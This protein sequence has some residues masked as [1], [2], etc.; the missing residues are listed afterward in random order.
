MQVRLT[1]LI[2]GVTIPV[3]IVSLLFVSLR[4][5]M[6]L[7]QNADER[8]QATSRALASNV[9][10]WL[11]H[12]VVTLTQ[13][14]SLP[15]VVSMDPA[16][17]KPALESVASA[18]THIILASTTGLNGTDVARSDGVAG[19]NHSTELWFKQARDGAPLVFQV[20]SD[21]VT[22]EPILV[23]SMP[24]RDAS[25]T[26]VGVGMLSSYLTEVAQEVQATRVGETGVAYVVDADNRVI[27]H[28]DPA[29]STRVRFVSASPPV[30]AMRE[31]TRG[32]L[33]FRDEEGELWR[34]YVDELDNGWGVVVQQPEAEAM[35]VLRSFNQAS[36]LI[37]VVGT[38]LL[39]VLASLTIRRSLHPIRLLT[40]TA[41]A[42]SAGDLTRVAPVESGDEIGILAHAFNSM[43]GQLRTFIDEL[44]QRVAERTQELSE[45]RNFVTTV[46]DTADALVVVLDRQGRIVRFN[47]A[48]EQTS[49]Y[50]S[51]EVVGRCVWDFLLLPEEQEKVKEVFDTLVATHQPGQYQNYWVARDGGLRLIDWSNAVLVDDNQEV[52]YVVATGI[53]VTERQKAE[54]Q[55]ATLAAVIEQTPATVVLTG[56]DGN[57]I[58]ANPAFEQITGYSV[59]EALGQNPRIVKSG[60]HD[61]A[62]Y[63]ELWDTITSG[64]TWEGVFINRRKDG[65]LY[66]EAATIF[67]VKAPSGETVNYAAVKRDVTEQVRVQ[68]DLE[69]RNQELATLNALAQAL[70]SS[71]ELDDLLTEALSRAIHTLG[72]AGGLISLADPRTGELVLHSYSGIPL[73]LSRHLQDRGMKG[74]LCDFV[75]RHGRPLSLDDLS[76]GAPVDVRALLKRGLR[77][78]VGAPIVHQERTLGT[79]CLFDRN[80]HPVTEGERDL[81]I[82]IGQQIGMAVENAR[83]FEETRRQVRDLSLLHDVSLAAVSG[84]HLEE[85]MQT[86]AQALAHELGDV[87]VAFMLLD[88][89]TGSLQVKA[90]A[91]RLPDSVENLQIRLDEGITGWVVRHGEPALVNDVARDPRY[92]Q[93]S[94]DTRS[95]LCVPLTVDSR[96][97]GVLNVESPRVDAFTRDD[98]RLLSTLASNLAVFIERARLFGEVEAA[99][100]ELAQRAEALERGNVRLQEVD[101]LKSEFLANMS[102]EIR[103]PL[104][105]IIGMTD[106]LLETPLSAEQRVFAV[107][108]RNS[109]DALL[110][111]LNDILDFSKIEAGKL[112][113]E[114]QPFDLRDC[115]EQ[116]LDLLAPKAA[117]KGLELAY[118][119]DDGVPSVVIGDVVRLRQILVNLLSNAV[120]FTEQG[121]VVVSVAS[122]H[123]EDNR[124]EIHFSVRDTGIGIPKERM[125]RLFRSFSQVDAS[126]TRKYGGTGLGLA[127]SQRLSELMGGTMW[128]ESQ[129]GAGSTFHFT[130]VAEPAPRQKR[131]Y[132]RATQPQLEGKRVLIID[133]NETNCRILARQVERW[134]MAPQAATSG[135]EALSWIQEGS[136][137]DI[138][139]LDMQMPDM[140]GMMLVR[141]IRKHLDPVTLPL[142]MLTSLGRREEQLESGE[143]AASL[144]KPVKPSQLYEVLVGTLAGRP[145]L[146]KETGPKADPAPDPDHDTSLSQQHPLRILLVEDNPVNQKVTLH[147][148]RRLGYGADVAANG[149]EAL[150]ALE[151]ATYDVVLMDIQMPEMDGEEATRRICARWP[152]GQRPHIIAMTAHAMKGDRERFLAAGMDDYVTKPVRLEELAEALRKS[153]VS[154]PSRSTPDLPTGQESPSP[155]PAARPSNGTPI[156]RDRLDAFRALMGESTPELINLFFKDSA[157]Q[158]A[159]LQQAIAGGDTEMMRRAAHTFKS[160]SAMLGALPLAAMCQELEDLGQTGDLEGAAERVAQLEAEYLA[161]KAELE[162]QIGADEG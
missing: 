75:Y 139:I 63:K 101:R 114:M 93:A 48:C 12:N 25:G 47:R 42:I 103:T 87:L 146:D 5:S 55:L 17:Q 28:P 31:G 16:R 129:P 39:L 104:N 92:V 90:S 148:L 82:V 115:I 105:A 119:L 94:A 89:E 58:Y 113:L 109:G 64:Q 41:I 26:I 13:L 132:L 112:E 66:H 140:D 21:R 81:L 8:L 158:L 135:A 155:S 117:E 30:I 32:L 153:P 80:P 6:L 40:D 52:E 138:A 65:S 111:L 33:T 136:S 56:L 79:V 70:A 142:V 54:Q 157:T 144:T 9:S 3:L 124:C 156:D 59:A 107:T 24:I 44:E 22:G 84:V 53:D 91:G 106:L 130:I 27:A 35:S 88:E 4:A 2:L 121:E 154:S 122:R 74:T 133:D 152:A 78:Y 1:G 20:V 110:S 61:E 18:H 57:I 43:T 102:H 14:V 125:D 118:I 36:G 72:F 45:Q 141:E 120:K 100:A 86:A 68:E 23:M 96:V 99:R 149:L 67:P 147:I 162:K 161:V 62:F 83:L 15:D 69:S 151:R 126:T 128:V 71:L 11:S 60:Y 159:E 131:V 46:L 73:P 108:V 145:L 51:Q 19:G 143:L 10:M 97:I 98:Q 85:T 150:Q 116:S 127:I 160:S 50:S 38:L 29:F 134:G 34:A 137:F 7:E 37:I 77:S 49:G 95:E 123:L 76:Q